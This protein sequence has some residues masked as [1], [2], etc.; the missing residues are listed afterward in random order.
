MPCMFAGR[1]PSL[2]LVNYSLV[3]P[4][5]GVFIG[6]GYGGHNP[7]KILSGLCKYLRERE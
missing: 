7:L 5:I 4:C 6:K 1:F 3:S 2:A